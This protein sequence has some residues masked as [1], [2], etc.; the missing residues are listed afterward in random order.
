MVS[1]KRD[2]SM[3]K[4]QIRV[5]VAA[6]INIPAQ[7]VLMLPAVVA[8]PAAD[9]IQNANAKVR[10]LGVTEAVFV[11]LDI[12]ILVREQIKPVGVEQRVMASIINAAA[13][14]LIHG[15]VE[16]ALV[17]QHTNMLVHQEI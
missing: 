15:K 12:S 14:L 8:L 11:V 1:A 5:N 16:L 4:Q 13:Q 6:H 17:I 10:I 7:A 2:M 3:I 9:Y